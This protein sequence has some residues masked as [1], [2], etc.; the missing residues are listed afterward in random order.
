MLMS[1]SAG[2][3]NAAWKASRRM[4]ECKPGNA[5]RRQCNVVRQNGTKCHAIAVRGFGRCFSHGGAGFMV[6]TGRTRWKLRRRIR[7]PRSQLK[8][9]DQL[10]AEAKAKTVL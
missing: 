3:G 7:L 2:S 8:S 6:L 1:R 5:N 9:E 4:S 10:K